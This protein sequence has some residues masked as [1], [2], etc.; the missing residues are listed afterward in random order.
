ML[1]RLSQV[2]NRLLELTF[3]T[4][5]YRYVIE[6]AADRVT[7]PITRIGKMYCWLRLIR[8]GE[9]W[10]VGHPARIGRRRVARGYG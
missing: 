8:G 2:A 5:M 1:C 4:D 3:I 7:S 9:L 6:T 10:V